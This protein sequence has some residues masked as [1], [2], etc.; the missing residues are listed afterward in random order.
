MIQNKRF[1][2]NLSPIM[3]LCLMS[4]VACSSSPKQAEPAKSMVESPPPEE[5]VRQESIENS[6]PTPAVIEPDVPDASPIREGIPD[7][8][9]VKKGDTLWDISSHFLKDPWLWPEV[10]YVNPKIRNPHLIYPGEIIALTWRDGKPTI[11][12]VGAEGAP[13]P[14]LPS[15]NLTTV[16][17][18]PS[19]REEKL[20]RAIDTIPKSAIFPFLV[21]PYILDNAA[22][23]NAPFIV[24]NF[25]D[26]IIS[27]RGKK[28]YVRPILDSDVINFNIVRKGRKYV[29]PD[30]GKFLGY[31]AI[32]LGTAKLLKLGD[33]ATMVVVTAYKEILKGD[34]LIPME[35]EEVDLNFFPRAP[36][37][38][39]AGRIISVAEG[40]Q[41][42]GQY[43]VVVV[44]KGKEDG[45]EP[46]H[47]LE[48]HQQ[49]ALV[50]SPR[51]RHK[52]RL[53][54]ERAGLLMI[55]KPYANVSYALVM[56]A[57]TDLSLYDY[58]Y[59]P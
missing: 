3:A 41:K 19:A 23:S 17:L 46:G 37:R 1:R 7:R 45:L 47:V 34:L 55:F 28:I 43:N 15:T 32:N 24:S 48:I 38:D 58:V 4:L 12:I 11:S 51:G 30:S 49:G 18:S 56:E 26:N 21:R 16:K 50:K 27:G 13:P 6:E 5:V 39:V 54:E 9:T 44:N 20:K 2:I 25:G 36:E 59:S 8:Y 14:P 33:P 42:I 22:L 35:I 10:W 53:P 29:D 52:I 57:F 40:V 31:E